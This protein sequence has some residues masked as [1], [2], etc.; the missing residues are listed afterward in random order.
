MTSVEILT[1]EEAAKILKISYHKM[2]TLLSLGKIPAKN[3]GTLKKPLWRV[4]REGLASYLSLP[5]NTAK[6]V[7]VGMKPRHGKSKVKPK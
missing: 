2:L 5:D 7:P 6:L 4:T 1:A 3:L